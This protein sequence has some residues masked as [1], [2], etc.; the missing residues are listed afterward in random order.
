MS[1]IYFRFLAI[2]KHATTSTA[3]RNAIVKNLP[4]SAFD[5][6]VLPSEIFNTTASPAL[7]I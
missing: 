6:P 7:L 3:E 5:Y 4:N 2:I 1:L